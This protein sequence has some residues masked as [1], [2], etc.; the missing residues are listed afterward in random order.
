MNKEII[1]IRTE[2][3]ERSLVDRSELPPGLDKILEVI[4]GKSTLGELVARLDST[5]AGVIGVGLAALVENDLIRDASEVPAAGSAAAVAEE[6]ARKA[7]ELRD[8]IRDRRK[9][10]RSRSSPA[11]DAWYKARREAEERARREAEEHARHQ[12]EEAAKRTAAEFARREAEEQARQAAVEQA[13]RAGEEAKRAAEEQAKRAAEEQAKQ[14]AAEE[15]RR[16]DEE[17]ARQ[18]A[19]E[20]ARRDAERA[21]KE[22]EEKAERD[23]K[24]AEQKAER[25]R[26]E[27]EERAWRVAEAEAKAA[28]DAARETDERARQRA[29][30]QA[31]LMAEEKAWLEAEEKTRREEDAARQR[32]ESQSGS[33]SG[34]TARSGRPLNLVKLGGIGAGSLLVA[35]LAAVHVISF[36][37]Q[38]PQFEQAL[39]GQFQ[40]PVKIKALHVALVSTPH[41][42]FEGVSIG[43]AGQIQVPTAKASG[44]LGSL[45][46]AKKSFKGIELN[47]PVISEE[48]LGWI[49][50][51][52]RQ[53]RDVPFGD[54]SAVGASL[55]SKR[56]SLPAFD[57]RMQFDESGAWKSITLATADKSI[58]AQLAA[59]G[60]TAEVEIRARSFKLPF[61]STL[62]LEDFAANGKVDKGGL[63]L[64]EFKGFLFGGTLGGNARL[65]WGDAWTLSGEATAR[66]IDTARLIPD[67]MSSAR[68]EGKANYAMQSADATRLFDSARVEGAFAIP[69]GTLLGVDLGSVLQ[70]G[71]IRGETKF[72]E[73]AGS[74][75]HEQG[76]TQLRQLRLSQGNMS[77]GGSVD[78]DAEKKIRGR[79]AAE[80]RLSTEM[81]RS[82]L[83]F[84]GTPSK[85]EWQR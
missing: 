66:Q 33:A 34:G 28:E 32:E 64:S 42:R 10:D 46:G 27:A 13:R 83:T 58:E 36:D 65:T 49:L 71:A 53:A 62:T 35:G 80:L 7:Q 48:G 12:A 68:L 77:A 70:G 2:K 51:G 59:K 20:Q 85:L 78:I 44:A 21:R 5:S 69:R 23:R 3:G 9:G 4:D 84:S 74:F 22:S 54:V 38:I 73:L 61:G 15:A 56:V 57:A 31:R 14:A 82:S 11:I 76:A 75:V 8:K 18:E 1:Y 16:R 26:K 50:F 25:D 67:L 81:R 41:L 79:V 63:T 30:V 39:G 55:E 52:S 72:S 17:R 37:G 40:Q 19:E 47:A 29:E 45:F 6:H 60:A 24:E 43:A